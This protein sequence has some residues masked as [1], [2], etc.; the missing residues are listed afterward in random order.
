MTR[1]QVQRRCI[2]ICS[3]TL[4][5][6]IGSYPVSMDSGNCE[7]IIFSSTRDGKSEIYALDIN[8]GNVRR[9]T[10]NS[11][12]DGFPAC[13]PD[14]TRIVFTS[15]RYDNNIEIYV[16]D[17]DGSNVKRLTDNSVYDFC[18][19]WSPD[20]TKIV[21]YSTKDSFPM[22]E[23]IYVMDIEGSNTIQLTHTT[24]CF[25]RDPKWCC[26]LSLSTEGLT[27]PRKDHFFL[28]MKYILVII[29]VLFVLYMFLRFRYKR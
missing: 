7:K 17:A 9:I 13:S 1:F 4:L 2:L 21:F 8:G 6:V 15:D 19:A 14:G 16:M 26:W 23:E 22:S 27:S 3:I 18:P 11:V 29:A 5:Y 12:S 28:E 20:G 10:N 25:N 24:S